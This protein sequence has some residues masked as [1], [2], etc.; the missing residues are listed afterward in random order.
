[1]CYFC[2]DIISYLMLGFLQLELGAAIK[3]RRTRTE[4][5]AVLCEELCPVAGVRAATEEGRQ[6]VEEHPLRPHPLVK[7]VPVKISL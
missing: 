7:I 3:A 2:K 5:V 4:L 1:M 6:L